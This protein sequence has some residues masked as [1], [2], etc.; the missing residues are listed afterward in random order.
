MEAALD[1]GVLSAIANAM[2]D[3]SWNMFFCKKKGGNVAPHSFG[4][5]P[6]RQPLGIPSD[7]GNRLGG[8]VHNCR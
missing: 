2:I 7:S 5:P 6:V 3:A 8:Q 4:E 1:V